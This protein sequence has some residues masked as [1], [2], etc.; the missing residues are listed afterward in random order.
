MKNT[1]FRFRY[2]PPLLLMIMAVCPR[3]FVI[4][5]C[6]TPLDRERYFVEAGARR[7]LPAIEWAPANYFRYIKGSEA[8]TSLWMSKEN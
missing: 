4:R 6:I 7:S 3:G 8:K 5:V 1:C 2:S